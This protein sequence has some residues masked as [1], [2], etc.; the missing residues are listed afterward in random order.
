MAYTNVPRCR[1]RTL[2]VKLDCLHRRVLIFQP[3]DVGYIFSV[4]NRRQVS[5]VTSPARD[6]GGAK[7][8][9]QFRHAAM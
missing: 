5:F 7:Y 6:S 8:C 4:R 9:F 2:E 1:L 3:I